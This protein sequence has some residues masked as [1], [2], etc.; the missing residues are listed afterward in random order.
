MTG[1]RLGVRG[2]WIG[3]L[4]AFL[5]V[6][7][8][9][10]RLYVMPDAVSITAGD[11]VAPFLIAWLIWRLVKWRMKERAPEQRYFVLVLASIFLAI[12]VVFPRLIKLFT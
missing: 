7:A 9:N 11:L 6:F 1:S 10:Y 2:F 12:A 5:V 3:T 4:I 8:I